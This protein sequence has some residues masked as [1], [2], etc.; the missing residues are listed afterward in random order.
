MEIE[1]QK[2]FIYNDLIWLNINKHIIFKVREFPWKELELY[3]TYWNFANSLFKNYFEN[4]IIIIRRL[5]Y[6]TNTDFISLKFLKSQILKDAD[7][8]LRKT[9]SI[10]LKTHEYYLQSMEAKIN[11]LR[12][13]RLGHISKKMIWEENKSYG[14][15]L[16]QFE[17]IVL[18]L[19]E[20]YR[21]L[22]QLDPQ[23]KFITLEYEKGNKDTDIEKILN[24]IARESKLLTL[25]NDKPDS[26]KAYLRKWDKEG[27]TIQ[28]LEIINY[29][30]TNLLKLSEIK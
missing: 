3:V 12:N 25:I 26:W 19:N 20:Y 2:K 13:K 30:R 5:Y 15:S 23:S 1:E 9:I 11:D 29:Y 27:S 14:I 10:E 8:D 18:S 17:K 6:E 28:R 16:K 4:S 22:L 7:N 24:S 21:V